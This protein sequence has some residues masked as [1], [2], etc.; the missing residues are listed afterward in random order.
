MRV[1]VFGAGGLG[2]LFGGFLAADGADVSFIARGAHLQAMRAN[3]LQIKSPLGDRHVPETKATDNPADVGPVDLLLVCVKSYDLEAA[4]N[5]FEPVLTPDTAIVPV[6]NGVEA[7]GYLGDR[8]GAHRVTSGIAHVPSNIDAPGLI[9]HKS[10]RIG[11]IVGALEGKAG[12]PIDWLVEAGCRTG[13]EVS[14]SQ[15]IEIDLWR[16]FILWAASSGVTSVS[17]LPIG[18]A[19]TIPELQALLKGL[20]LETD[21]VARARGVGM[22]DDSVE[23]VLKTLNAAP[24]GM[25]SSTLVDVEAGKRLEIDVGVG[26]VMRMSEQLGLD[27]PIART[28]YAA[29]KPWQDGAI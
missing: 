11:L 28:I 29:L 12:E 9:V 18:A 6:L 15:D 10:P 13:M 5:Q 4:A 25:K 27:A 2:G 22:P 8:F 23:K 16:K 1:C 7:M 3:G 19:Q 14:L 21:A 24:E 20:M 26:A 17:R